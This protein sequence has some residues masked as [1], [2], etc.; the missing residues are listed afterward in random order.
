MKTPTQSTLDKIT[1]TEPASSIYVALL[2]RL[3]SIGPFDVEL[4]ASSLHVVHQRAFLGV[5]YRKNGLLINIVLD[6]PLDSP[7]LKASERVSRSRYHHEVLVSSP[8][9]IDAELV[10]WMKEA[11]RLTLT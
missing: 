10:G 8:R 2:K 9:E 5:H 11:H 7:R 4:K 1:E 6:R 3:K